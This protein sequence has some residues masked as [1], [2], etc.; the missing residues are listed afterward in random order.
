MT[1]LYQITLD[2]DE[3]A[4]GTPNWFAS[5]AEAEQA[6]ASLRA[7]GDDMDTDGWVAEKATIDHLSD[8]DRTRAL[9]AA[10]ILPAD[11]V[12]CECGEATGER[13]AWSGPI[14]ETVVVEW[15]PEYLRESHRAAG[16]SGTH[17]AN[18][19]LQLRVERSC[20]DRLAQ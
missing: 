13:C 12:R 18:G 15:M 9:V 5:R 16:N 11:T 4:A 17:P 3:F 8:D 19:S 6:I 1:T 20:A 10:G 2:G 7:L 14:T